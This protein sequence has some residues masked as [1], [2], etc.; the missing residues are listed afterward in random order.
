MKKYYKDADKSIIMGL[1]ELSEGPF[2][3]MH[4]PGHK[5][6]LLRDNGLP[7]GLDITEIEGMDDL[8]HAGGILKE[9]MERA[10]A[11]FGSERTWFLVNGS[12]CGVMA[13]LGAV[14]KHGDK[15]IMARNCHI[16]AFNAAR[17]LG[18][19]TAFVMPEYSTGY[20][21]SGSITASSLKRAIAGN[22]DAKAVILTSPTYEGVVSDIEALSGICHENN[23][24]LII[25]A[26]HGAHFR[27]YQSL[28][29]KS[30]LEAGA[31]IVVESA[32]KTLPSLTQTALLHLRDFKYTDEKRIEE[33]LSIFESSS[34]SYILMASLD[35]CTDILKREGER[36]FSEYEG[37]LVELYERLSGLK[38]I[39]A[40]GAS[41]ITS[42]PFEE[43]PFSAIYARDPSRVLIS[44]RA[45]GLSGEELAGILRREYR[46]EPEMCSGEHVLLLTSVCDT[47][48]GFDRLCDA[49]TMLDRKSPVKEP[50]E[51][52][53]GEELS[54]ALY[55]EDPHLNGSRDTVC[56]TECR[57]TI[58]EAAESEQELVRME[59]AEGRICGE[60]VYLYPP[61][62]PLLIP[63]EVLTEGVLRYMKGLG[64]RLKKTKSPNAGEIAVLL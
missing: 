17:L 1:S 32:H 41:G 8:H 60:Y 2:Y 33:Q 58:T 36:L 4:M 31:D 34:P 30:A 64:C 25:D 24:P 59:E 6:R 29:L 16:C 51:N 44:G 37:R 5:R 12:T 11:V 55:G 19:S 7:Y 61:G 3:P 52:T 38:S 21:I 56:A 22:P 48:E 15:V 54:D 14:L 46:I 9:A 42:L 57:L 23:I 53:E 43:G 50:A 18:L 35:E 39:K 45:A 40:A 10:A 49:V 63:G 28:P 62:I 26:A 47:K 27:F 13:A 20:R